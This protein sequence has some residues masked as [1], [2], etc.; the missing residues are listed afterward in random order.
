MW[1]LLL[2]LAE[3]KNFTYTIVRPPDGKWGVGDAD[4][5]WNGMLGM[6]KRKEVSHFTD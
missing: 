1:D 3:S 6:V 5:N 4:G 2:F